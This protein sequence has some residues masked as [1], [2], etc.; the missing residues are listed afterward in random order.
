L[1]A[2]KEERKAWSEH[3]DEIHKIMTR[4]FDW[5]IGERQ[6]RKRGSILKDICLPACVLFLKFCLA[7]LLW[8]LCVSIW[9]DAFNIDL[10]RLLCST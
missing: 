8:W 5:K 4:N 7:L 2:T 3:L 9:L 10:W 6:T 1:R